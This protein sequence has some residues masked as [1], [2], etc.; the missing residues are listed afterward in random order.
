VEDLNTI[1]VLQVVKRGV[2]KFLMEL[3]SVKFLGLVF[4]G[5]L[6]YRR[7]LDGS[8][9]LM[10]MLAILGIREG[11]EFIQSKF[12]LSIGPKNG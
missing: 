10:G 3:T 5:F 2:K 12:G 4:I 1:T 9:G 11:M 8:L 7:I 6:T